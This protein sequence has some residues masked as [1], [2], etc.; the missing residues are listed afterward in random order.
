MTSEERYDRTYHFGPVEHR[1]LV[2]SLAL[3]Q[4][5]VLGLGAIAALLVF[6]TAPNVLGFVAAIAL[7]TISG[8]IAFGRWRGRTIE[9]WAP[10]V[11]RWLAV[12]RS[13]RHLF[14]SPHPRQGRLAAFGH[15]QQE[16]DAP[17]LPAL[18]E[19]CRLLS[20]PVADGHRVGVIHDK[21][22]RAYTAIMAVRIGAF[23]LLS[24]AEQE[25][26]LERWGRILA[27]LAV[28]GGTVRRLQTLERTLP[29][30]GDELERY[31]AESSARHIGEDD[32]RRRSYE[33][34]VD[35]AASITQDHELLVAVQVDQ[36]RAWAQ[37]A[38][39]GRLRDLDRDEQA[40]AILAREIQALVGRFELS[41]LRVAGVLTPDEC[42]HRIARAFDPFAAPPRRDIGPTA[43]E[44]TWDRYRADGAWHRTF[45]VREWPRLSVGAGF[46]AGLLLT[47]EAVR[48]V[49][50]VFEPVS[51]SRARGAVEAAITSDDAE[52]RL[53]AERGFRTSAR[54]RKQHEAALRREREL[55][56]GHE[57]L[58]FAGFVTVSG[59]SEAELDEACEA[60]ATASRRAYLELDVLY[61]EQDASFVNGS[62]PMARGL[63]AARPLGLGS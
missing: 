53:R 45:W 58:R 59:R 20:V 31:L 44:A 1:G 14:R 51:P 47:A 30:Q 25:R 7:M 60:V 6:R 12:K 40:T 23:G 34:L 15:R 3:G 62:L 9:Q 18:L 37:A 5:A 8:G 43:T 13:G 41:E 61:G 54:R 22:L 17:S 63:A 57:E 48:S 38:R 16:H 29:S 27:S 4:V 10:V 49:S 2:G 32:P 28:E 42:A 36:R 46:F 24:A 50:I 19:G 11:S 56:E 55:A 39:D 52:E 21:A 26:R 33:L 35:S